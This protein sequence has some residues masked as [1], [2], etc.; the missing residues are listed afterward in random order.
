[1]QS[2]IDSNY[3]INKRK[4]SHNNLCLHLQI[5]VQNVLHLYNLKYGNNSKTRPARVNLK[6]YSESV[7]KYPIRK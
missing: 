6:Q 3:N 5:I 4:Q 2:K 1:M 7:Q